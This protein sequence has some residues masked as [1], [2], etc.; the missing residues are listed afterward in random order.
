MQFETPRIR[1]RK[2][3]MAA[4]ERRRIVRA[5]KADEGKSPKDKGEEL[6]PFFI[7]P[8]Y[9]LLFKYMQNVKNASRLHRKPIPSKRKREFGNDAKEFAQY[10]H[11]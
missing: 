7:P 2:Y 8:R 1:N 6:P 11:A 9:K 4:K 5:R 10:V 3:K